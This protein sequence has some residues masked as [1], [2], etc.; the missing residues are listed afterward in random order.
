MKTMKL[1][2]S[3]SASLSGL[4]GDSRRVQARANFKLTALAKAYGARTCPKDAN[5]KK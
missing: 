4:G 5:E 1:S 2:P 3:Q